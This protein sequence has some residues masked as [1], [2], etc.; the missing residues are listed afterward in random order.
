MLEILKTNV[1]G[2]PVKTIIFSQFT[3]MLDVIEPFLRDHNIAH[4]RCNSNLG[5]F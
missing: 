3:T 4:G 1:D 2:E 5:S